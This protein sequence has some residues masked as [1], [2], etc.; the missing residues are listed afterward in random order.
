MTSGKADSDTAGTPATY[1][2][3]SG[4][5]SEAI[6]LTF[7]DDAG[8][9]PTATLTVIV[10][11]A[12]APGPEPEAELDPETA[13]ESPP[14]S[15]GAAARTAGATISIPETVAI[16]GR[17]A[18]SVPVAV[19][20]GRPRAFTAT[21]T[22]VKGKRELAS[23]GLTLERAGSGVIDVPLPKKVKPGTYV[24]AVRVRTLKGRHVGKTVRRTVTLTR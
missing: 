1:T 11:R 13:P 12:P 15:G 16:S 3:P 23:A 20:A 22:T 9:R 5:A 18:R 4:S 17:R 6:A 14:G 8:G 2:F 19:E 10:N 21:V 7:T 24:I